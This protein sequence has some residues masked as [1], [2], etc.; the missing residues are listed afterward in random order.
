MWTPI[1]NSIFDFSESKFTVELC[2][3]FDS[4]SLSEEV[5]EKRELSLK[6]KNDK[7]TLFHFVSVGGSPIGAELFLLT[8]NNLFFIEM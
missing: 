3:L 8:S 7:L 5:C 6:V 2:T 4:A 1:D